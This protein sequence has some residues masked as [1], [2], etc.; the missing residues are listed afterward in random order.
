VHCR[1]KRPGNPYSG[2]TVGCHLQRRMTEKMKL[3]QFFL[4]CSVL[5][6]SPYVVNFVLLFPGLHTH[7]AGIILVTGASSGIGLSAAIALAR[8]GY[9]VVAG[10]RRE[11]DASYIKSV[12]PSLIPIILDVTKDSHVERSVQTV[13]QYKERYGLQFVGLVNNAGVSKGLPLEIQPF[14]FVE[15]VYGVNTFGLLKVT[16]EF[17]PLL[18]RSKG[19]IINVGS[20]AGHLATAGGSTYAG[21]KHALE[22]ISDSLRRELFHHEVSVSLVEPA[23]VETAI[24]GK[25]MSSNDPVS[26]LS[27]EDYSLYQIMFDKR[28]ATMEKNI[29]LASSTSVTDEAITHAMQSLYPHS[30][31]VVANVQGIPAV[32]LMKLF[33]LLPDRVAD[34]ILHKN[35][36]G[37]PAVL[38]FALALGSFGISGKF[39]LALF[40]KL[41]HL[42]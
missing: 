40:R 32:V 34:F 6:L 8:K 10:V 15:Q 42:W 22:A 11:H 27:K 37:Y 28:E 5:F 29:R 36:T 41:D 16:K 1:S 26:K 7:Q 21:T 13:E 30:R 23:F 4:L 35:M 25:S 24:F 31:Y 33:W 17:I 20:V 3:T 2:H 12:E 14:S 18:R 38:L 39:I 19:R 9:T